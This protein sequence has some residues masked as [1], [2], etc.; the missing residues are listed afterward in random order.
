MLGLVDDALAAANAG[1]DALAG[2]GV[3]EDT[4]AVAAGGGDATRATALGGGVDDTCRADTDDDD[5][6]LATLLCGVRTTL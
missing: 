4:R 1:A 2:G 5:C 6:E 3:A